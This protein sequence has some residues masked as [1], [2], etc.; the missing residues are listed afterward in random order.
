MH[1]EEWE[2]VVVF[3]EVVFSAAHKASQAKPGVRLAL[4]C[5]G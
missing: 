1:I 4:T 3:L 5:L 2:V